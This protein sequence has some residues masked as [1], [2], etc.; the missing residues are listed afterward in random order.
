MRLK[1]TLLASAIGLSL[2]MVSRARAAAPFTW[3]LANTVPSLGGG[4]FTAD[5][6][7]S[8][9]Y[10]HNLAPPGGNAA[11][12]F[13]L[14]INGFGNG[15]TNVTPAGLG[16]TYGLYPQPSPHFSSVISIQ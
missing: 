5:A 7:S 13:I 9:D 8:T 4:Q 10:L 12:S 14:Q 16:T 1:P 6:I 3:D 11:E 15:T 2:V